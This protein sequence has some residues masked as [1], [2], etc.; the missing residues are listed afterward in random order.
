MDAPMLFDLLVRQNLKKHI[1][2]VAL[3]LGVTLLCGAVVVAVGGPLKLKLMNGLF[4]AAGII[5]GYLTPHGGKVDHRGTNG[6]FV[7]ISAWLG[8]VLFSPQLLGE[9]SRLSG[10]LFDLMLNNVINGF[11]IIAGAYVGTLLKN[12]YG[13]PLWWTKLGEAKAPAEPETAETLIA[14]SHWTQRPDKDAK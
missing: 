11:V 8:Y 1:L 13:E 12:R 4:L 2:P 9:S 3:A 7:M 14:A 6:T 5:I 10:W